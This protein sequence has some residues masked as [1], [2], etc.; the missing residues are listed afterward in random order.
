MFSLSKI[1]AA[2]CADDEI[3][4]TTGTI[5]HQGRIKDDWSGQRSRCIDCFES[6]FFLIGKTQMA[7][8]E[9]YLNIATRNL[10]KGA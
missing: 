10:K 5:Q 2:A 4:L 1:G 9:K 8:S 6:I 7:P 3:Q